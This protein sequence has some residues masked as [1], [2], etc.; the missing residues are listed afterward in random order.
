V[1]GFLLFQVGVKKGPR[2]GAF[3]TFGRRDRLLFL[4]TG[5]RKLT[6]YFYPNAE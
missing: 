3:T 5:Q 6:L 2:N 1:P 4:N